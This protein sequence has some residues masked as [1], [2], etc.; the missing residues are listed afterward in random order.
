[1]EI[2]KL[3]EIVTAGGNIQ[4]AG[5]IVLEAEKEARKR[6]KL[7]K[8]GKCTGI[9][10]GLLQLNKLTGGWQPSKLIILAARPSMGKTAIMLHFSIRAA[11]SGIPVCIY[12]L[13]TSNTELINR[14]ILACSNID[15]CRYKS[16]FMSHEDWNEFEKAKRELTG[17]PIYI[18]D[19]SSSVSMQY[20][21]N[22]SRQMQKKGKCGIVFV[23]YLQ[24]A[25]MRLEERNRTREQEVAQA[26][27]Q[28]KIIAKELNVPFILLSQLSRDVEKRGGTRRP[29]LSDLRESGAIEQDADLVMFIYRAAYYG[30]KE[31]AAGNSLAGIGELIM[32]KNRDGGVGEVPFSHNPSMTKIFDFD[33]YL[34]E[35]LKEVPVT[36]N[37]P[38]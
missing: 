8:E 25:E 7:A 29:M 26:S 16:G 28:A 18:D 38:F 5:S 9:D 20:I 6:E 21:R 14:M 30:M 36:E 10:T 11:R 19:C 37:E 22:H 15:A 4:S 12:N 13:E 23:D 35:A 31:D 24:L 27:R 2:Q 32:A 3:G 34:E 33:P 17:L 1:M